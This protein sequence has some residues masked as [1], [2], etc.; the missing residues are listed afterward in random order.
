[1]VCQ[2]FI[3]IKIILKVFYLIKGYLCL[4][5]DKDGTAHVGSSS[6]QTLQSPPSSLFVST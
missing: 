3:L 4:M 5:Y 2:R 6:C 1:M